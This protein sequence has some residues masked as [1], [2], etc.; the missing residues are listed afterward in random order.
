MP[1]DPNIP[2]PILSIRSAS[3]SFDSL[4]AVQRVSLEVQKGEIFGIV[5]P[6]GAGKTT[7]L[8]LVCGLLDLHEGQIQIQGLDVAKKT[9]QVRDRI[10]Y[11]AQRFSLYGDLTVEENLDFYADLFGLGRSERSPLK[12]RLLKMTRME[13]FRDRYASRLSGG[14][15]QKLNLMCALL[16]SP[17]LLILDEPTNGVDPIS[18]RD[19]WVILYQLVKQGLTVVIATA[20]IDEAERCGRVALMNRGRVILCDRPNNLSLHLKEDYFRLSCSDPREARRILASDPAVMSVQPNGIHTT[21]FLRP[22]QGEEA[23]IRDLLAQSELADVVLERGRP[24]V[25]DVFIAVVERESGGR[26]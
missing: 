8:R 19:F 9:D 3:R 13:P 18:R 6:D 5:G 22:E 1:E 20:Y 2:P 11:M 17:E 4:Q 16:H 24:S 23:R 26:N 14:M 10:G 12:N 15:K 25:E 7:L 21:F